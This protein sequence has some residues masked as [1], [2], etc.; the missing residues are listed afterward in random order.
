MS[1][2]E[3][4]EPADL[5]KR[6]E[7]RQRLAAAQDALAAAQRTEAAIS[8]AHEDAERIEHDA[9]G[10]WEVVRRQRRGHGTELAER[11]VEAARSGSAPPEA[12][13]GGDQSAEALALAD[14]KTARRAV[15]ALDDELADAQAAMAAA[16]HGLD[17]AA[18][19][20]LI[21]H[22]ETLIHD[23]E[24]AKAKLDAIRNAILAADHVGGVVFPVGGWQPFPLNVA[25][26]TLLYGHQPDQAVVQPAMQR[27]RD[28]RER[29]KADPDAEPPPA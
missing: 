14:V 10:A 5:G 12:I 18:Q 26:R 6:S 24:A 23:G 15:T 25:G 2:A 21:E 4:I 19:R 20:V 27:F 28:F 3:T 1:A 9:V 22:V 8:K 11:L 16:V 13:P 29:L 7:A 17:L